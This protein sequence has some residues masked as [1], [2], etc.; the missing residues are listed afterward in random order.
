MTFPISKQ[1]YMQL[2]AQVKEL[3]DN[4]KPTVENKNHSTKGR[5]YRLILTS[6]GRQ[7]DLEFYPPLVGSRKELASLLDRELQGLGAEA[8]GT[9]AP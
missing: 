3:H 4:D 2:L 5:H 8:F 6:G 1:K 7:I 9:P